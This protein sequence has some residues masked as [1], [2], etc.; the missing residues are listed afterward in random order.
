MSST[1]AIQETQFILIFSLNIPN[2]FLKH[3]FHFPFRNFAISLIHIICWANA[4]PPTLWLTIDNCARLAAGGNAL[5]CLCLLSGLVGIKALIDSVI[6]SFVCTFFFHLISITRIKIRIM[7]FIFLNNS[8]FVA[9][10]N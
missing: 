10:K 5:Y 6:L 2:Q 4:E 3:I 8:L 1:V 7:N 9:T